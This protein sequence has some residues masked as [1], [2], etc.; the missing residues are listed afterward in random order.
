M[1]GVEITTHG[2]ARALQ[3]FLT[4]PQVTPGDE[5][6]G[7]ISPRRKRRSVAGLA[8]QTPEARQGH[9]L[10][11]YRGLE[12]KTGTARG[13]WRPDLDSIE[14]YKARQRQPR[15]RGGRP[16]GLARLPRRPPIRGHRRFRQ[17]R[18]NTSGP[19]IGT[20]VQLPPEQAGAPGGPI[21]PRRSS[22]RS[23]RSRLVTSGPLSTP[24]RRQRAG[25]RG[26]DARAHGAAAC[27]RARPAVDRCERSGGDARLVSVTG[28]T[29][30]G[31]AQCAAVLDLAVA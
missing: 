21:E 1:P 31:V 23:S 25:L 26:G 17:H 6:R 9:R 30:P 8:G 10:F 12:T 27:R 4:T 14:V 29:C 20:Y 2:Q 13:E 7:T 5:R 24:D 11:R 22:L 28:C 19:D 3:V 18:F 16:H 15:A